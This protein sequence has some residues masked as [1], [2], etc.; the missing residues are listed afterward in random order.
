M[1]SATADRSRM[2]GSFSTFS[3]S[4]RRARSPGTITAG[5]RR[6]PTSFAARNRC[7]P[8]MML[9]PFPSFRSTTTTGARNPTRS[10]E[11]TT[12]FTWA[13]LAFRWCEMTSSF[14]IGRSANV[15]SRR[16]D[17]SLKEKPASDTDWGGRAGT[18]LSPLDDPAHEG[19]LAC[20]FGVVVD[21]A[22]E[23]DAE[24]DGRVPSFVHDP[25]QVGVGDALD[26]ADRLL[27]DGVVI[28]DEQIPGVDV[29][30]GHVLAPV[31]VPRIPRVERQTETLHPALR[32]PDLVCLR[33]IRDVV[34]LDA[35]QVPH[36]PGDRVGVVVESN[37]QLLRRQPLDRAVHDG[38]DS[39]EG[40]D[41]ELGAGH[42][43][44]L[45]MSE[46]TS[47]LQRR[48]SLVACTTVLV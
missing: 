5:I 3:V 43:S 40:V 10:T 29:H 15:R 21:H 48:E 12:R 39:A 33:D 30:F 24:R 20:V 47:Q 41:E 38:T 17:G 27:V 11:S 36:Q 4:I 18:R 16:V 19:G 46:S 2:F 8:S 22:H 13:S 23:S 9:Y 32:G 6:R 25:I 34:V 7:W 45:S 31:P 37:R 14:P 28:V 35:G 44:V 1:E 26:V 42:W